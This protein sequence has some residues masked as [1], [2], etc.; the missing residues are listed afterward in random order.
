M[1]YVLV[2]GL[3]LLATL[4]ILMDLW[5]AKCIED[6]RISRERMIEKVRDLRRSGAIDAVEAIRLVRAVHDVPFDEH[7]RLCMS[8]QDPAILYPS[9][10]DSDR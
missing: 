7:V 4:I 8:R 9:E 6:C 3:G 5:E 10:L 2:L 1:V